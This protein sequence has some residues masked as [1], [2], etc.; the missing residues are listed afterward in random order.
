MSWF[1]FPSS[2]RFLFISSDSMD[3]IKVCSNL[4]PSQQQDIAK[5]Q[6][7][8]A[9]WIRTH[10]LVLWLVTI[11]TFISLRLDS[12]SSLLFLQSK[13]KWKK[14]YC[15]IKKKRDLHDGKV[16]K[17]VV[18][19][20]DYGVCAYIIEFKEPYLS[21]KFVV[22]PWT[23]RRCENYTFDCGADFT[24]FLL[25]DFV[26]FLIKF[27]VLFYLNLYGLILLFRYHGQG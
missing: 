7:L 24:D 26:E 9:P 23:E 4:I 19:G 8:L 12:A 18:T 5:R 17:I 3:K 1:Y 2:S 11:H 16:V 25:R 15:T 10:E 6:V 14:K 21:Y 27:G 13:W 22:Q 20:S